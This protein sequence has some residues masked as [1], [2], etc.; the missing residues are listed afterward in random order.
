M[1]I[2]KILILCII[3]FVLPAAAFA[4]SDI[5][6]IE[7]DP[8]SSGMAGAGVGLPNIAGAYNLNPAGDRVNNRY[9]AGIGYSQWF[10]GVNLTTLQGKIPISSNL[11]MGMNLIYRG[12]SFQETDQN[13]L[14][15]NSNLSIKS[16]IENFNL[17]TMVIDNLYAGVGIKLI[18]DYLQDF[19]AVFQVLDY[20]LLYEWK[21]LSAGFSV[22]N[23]G[24]G[25]KIT[26][27]NQ[28]EGMNPTDRAGVG[29][30]LLDKK[31]DLAF[32]LL[33]GDELGTRFKVGAEYNIK[34]LF[35][36]RIGY[37]GYY[38]ANFN[39]SDGISIGFGIRWHNLGL[40]YSWFQG[41]DLNDDNSFIGLKGINKIGLKYVF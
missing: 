31:L 12:I 27:L 28:G 21:F 34:N 17:S 41:S 5:L 36:I 2:V 1:K 35:I 33:W 26:Y 8:I 16:Y 30:R 32:D 11:T 24:F 38:G 22:N 9:E 18:Q 3:V 6:L 15:M 13:G 4:L 7:I 25:S 19:S 29:A 39:F 20:G 23:Y 14:L 37:D 10:A 40:D